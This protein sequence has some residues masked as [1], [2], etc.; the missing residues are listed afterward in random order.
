[1]TSSSIALLL[2]ESSQPSYYERA[3]QR[4][5]GSNPSVRIDHLTPISFELNVRSRYYDQRNHDLIGEK[6][7]GYFFYYDAI[8]ERYLLSV[9]YMSNWNILTLAHVI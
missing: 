6:D 4:F 7:Q 9:K 5:I 2:F 8:N 1:M 3:V